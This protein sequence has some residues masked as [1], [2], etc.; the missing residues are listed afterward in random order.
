[1]KT[2]MIGNSHNTM[3][4]SEFVLE[5]NLIA[6]YLLSK[7]YKKADF[8]KLLKHEVERLKKDAYRHVALKLAEIEAKSK[9]RQNIRLPY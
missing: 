7:G 5:Q 1:M 8:G 3:E 6:E 4:S 9:F 2:Q